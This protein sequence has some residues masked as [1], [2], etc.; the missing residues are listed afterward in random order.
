[1][2]LNLLAVVTITFICGHVVDA[3]SASTSTSS[4][5]RPSLRST[6]PHDSLYCK[7]IKFSSFK[8]KHVT[9]CQVNDLQITLGNVLG[10]GA[11]GIVYEVTNF[12]STAIKF[13]QNQRDSKTSH[14][15]ENENS[16]MK[17][18]TKN[19]I[20]NVGEIIDNLTDVSSDAKVY[21]IGLKKY[22]KDLIDFCNDDVTP[23]LH[24]GVH[25]LLQF[26]VK[27]AVKFF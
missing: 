7:Q 2:D 9:H 12:D 4:I 19:D 8:A 15:V 24:W 6:S 13:V 26:G 23:K 16:I 1:M 20:P 5:S 22:Y 27:L 21:V 10:E 17:S 14:N 25:Q 3:T 11:F 18:L